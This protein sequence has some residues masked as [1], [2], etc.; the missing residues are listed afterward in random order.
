MGSTVAPLTLKVRD[1][2]CSV[3]SSTELNVPAA[4]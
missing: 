4:P 1:R 2:N 3:P